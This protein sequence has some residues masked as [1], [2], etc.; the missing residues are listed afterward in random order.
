MKKLIFAFVFALIAN[1]SL[2]TNNC[3][4][5]WEQS[6]GPHGAFQISVVCGNGD[7]I[8]TGATGGITSLFG[9]YKSTNNGLKWK[10]IG[11]E[12][13]SIS[14]IGINTQ[15]NMIY[16]AAGGAGIFDRGIHKKL[17]I[18]EKWTFAGMLNV[19]VYSIGFKD[20]YIFAG[21]DGIHRS[22]DQGLTWTQVGL[23]GRSVRS[24]Q[25]SGNSIFVGAGN[26]LFLSTDNGDTWTTKLTTSG[27]YV[28]VALNNNY[29]VVASNS[30]STGIYYSSNSGNTWNSTNSI[31]LAQDVHYFNNHF[32][33]ATAADSG[34]YKSSNNGVNWTRINNGLNK[35]TV[36]PSLSSNNIGVYCGT[37][38]SN[39]SGVYYTSDL[40]ANWQVIGLPY[41]DITSIISSGSNLIS[42]TRYE[43]IFISTNNGQ[44]WI[45]SNNGLPTGNIGAIAHNGNEIYAGL[46]GSG[47]QMGVYRSTNNGLNWV[48][49]GLSNVSIYAIGASGSNVFA[50]GGLGAFY[51]STN[52]GMNW[53][54]TTFSNGASA[55]LIQGSLVFAGG[56]SGVYVSSDNGNSWSQTPLTSSIASL[57]M[58]GNTIYAGAYGSGGGL[59]KSTNN[60]VNWSL[61]GL[62]GARIE[63]IAING[64]NIFAGKL[65]S[66]TGVF[67]STN[68]GV[69]WLDKNQ[70]FTV[71]TGITELLISG[72]NIFAGTSYNSI[73]R[74][75]LSEIIGVQN[76][77]SEIPSGFYLYQNYPNPFNPFTNIEFSIPKHG[78]VKITVYDSQGKEIANLLNQN[79]SMGTYK[80]NFDGTSYSSGIYFYKME[81]KDFSSTK[82][83]I[84][85][86]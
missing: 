84:L 22:S 34:I 47:S 45:P 69:T 60:G 50:A 2:N 57:V 73:W 36:I 26:A 49:S 27:S 51:K 48:F 6:N 14:A 11:L 25:V 58:D 52:G 55:I 19:Y 30:S 54:Q 16:A 35:S 76:I 18:E 42:G 70:G 12:G 32:F 81:T 59:Y 79:L 37:L 21:A 74:R 39:V 53:S 72:N 8:Y 33:T 15:T 41:Q 38:I 1:C 40:G 17:L 5:Q 31:R 7:D 80:V 44:S 82:R 78:N 46:E 77:S 66:Q 24:I 43:G 9:V 64:N 83:M 23:S 85:L 67:M 56:S 75:S 61:V 10:R 13:N 86:K 63:A 29:V 28:R 3:N 71:P 62:S 20:N 68:N 65:G 4:A